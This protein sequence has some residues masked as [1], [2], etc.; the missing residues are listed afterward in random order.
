VETAGT[1][2]S[3]N[4][5][6]P[7]I[8][9]PKGGG[10]LRSIGEKFGA[11]PVT[12]TGTLSIPIATS[13]GRSGFGP[14][15]GLSYDSGAGNGPFGFGWHLSLPSITRKTDKGLPRYLD[16]E[17][18]D[19]FIFAGA[20]DLVPELDSD[21]GR[22]ADTSSAPGYTIHRY[23]PRT[24]GLFARIERWTRR[25]DGDVHWRS[26]SRDN[27]L[28]LYGEDPEAR[29]TDPADPRRIFAWL[30]CETRDSWGNAVRYTYKPEDGAGVD[31]TR[32]HERTRGGPDD[33][34]RTANRYLKRVRY[35]NRVPLLDVTGQRPIS[36]TTTQVEDAGWM[37]EVVLDYGE[38]DSD[39]PTPHDAGP[40]SWRDDPFSSYRSG[41]EV[42]TGRR[43]RRVLMFHHFPDK[44]EIGDDCLVSSTDFT[45]DQEQ[46]P[47]ETRHSVYSFLRTVTRTGYRRHG[48]GY[49]KRSLP[50][51]ELHYSQPVVQDTV[52]DLDSE[53]LE[54]LPIG[55]DGTAYRWTDLHGEGIP[56]ILTE[57][58]GAWHYKR[59]LSPA[60]EHPPELAPLELVATKPNVTLAGDTQF[61]DLAGDGQP[62]VVVLAGPVPG[63]YEHDDAGG[64][65]PF[66]PFTFPLNRDPRDPWLRFVDLDG[67]G[68]LDVLVGEDDAFTWQASRAEAGF[69][70]P[71]RVHAALDEEA[72][73]RQ[74]LSDGTQSIHLADM[75]GDGLND[76]VRIRNGEVCYW[77]NLG[78]GRF[79]AKVTMDN[80][81]WFDQPDQFDQRRIR[82]ADIDGSGTADIIY[83]ARD[84]VRLYFNQC[85]NSW[86]APQRLRVFP[87]IDDLVT[88]APTDLLGNGA[89]CLVWSSALPGDEGRQMRYVDLIG[90]Q[91]PHLLVKVVNNLG[92]ETQVEYAPSTKFYLQ[93]RR[94]GAPWITRLP[95]PVHV[96]ERVETLDRIGGNR[97]TTQ[98]AYHHGYFDGEEREFRG[99][100][101]VEQWDTERPIASAND[102]PQPAGPGQETTSRV[103]PVLT[104]TW[105]HTGI[106]RGR[107]H[108]SDFFAGLLDES[109]PGEYYREPGLTD[110]QAR[111]RLL[112]DTVL[113]S[114]LAPEEQREACRALKGTMLRQEIYGL[115]G[116]DR[117]AVPYTVS[118][119]CFTIRRV[120]PRGPNRHAVFFTH[121]SEVISLNYERDPA[122]PRMQHA[123][124]LEVDPYGN[125]LKEIGVGYG[126]R[127][128]STDPILTDADRVRQSRLLVTYTESSFTNPI[129]AADH[130][131]T[132]LPAGTRTYELAGFTPEGGAERFSLDE[133]VRDGFSSLASAV[134]IPY[135]QAADDVTRQKRLVEHIRTRYR[136]DDLTGLLPFGE[137][138]PLGLPGETYR[139]ALTPG[140]LAKV[141][142][143]QQGGQPDEALLPD[144]GPL[145]EAK[146]EDQGGYRMLDGGWWI[147]SGAVF[148]HPEADANDP[149]STATLE[150]AGARQH[151]YLPRKVT[152]P[153]GHS[154]VV[155]YDEHDLL[156][157]RTGD[158][159]GN[160]TSAANDY[161]VLRPGVITDANHNQT[162][163]AFD[164]L[165]MVVATAVMGKQ[166][167]GVGDRLEDM[168]ADPPLADVQ[169]FAADPRTRAPSLLGKATTRIV[170]DLARFQRVGQPAFA[171][172]LARETHLHE[173]G[174]DQTRIQISCTYSDGFGREIQKKVQA[175]A[176]DAPQRQTPVALPTG[177]V[178][179]GDLMRDAQGNPLSA[180]TPDRWVGSGRTVFN[181]KGKPVRQYEPFFSATH[182]YE[183]EPEMTDTGVSA[184]LFYDPIERLVAALHP[185]HTYDKTVFGPWHQT[186]WDVNDTVA[187]AGDQTGDPRTDPDIAAA[188]REYFDAQPP[189]WQTWH[190]QRIDGQLGAAERDAARQAAVHADTP[191]T[192][193]LD[194]LGRRFLTVARNRSERDGAIIE[195]QHANRVDLDLE[196][197]QRTL[198]DAKGRVVVRLDYDLLGKLLHQA[199]MEAGE[200]WILSDAS[201][202][203]IR[204][205]DGR[206][207]LRRMTYDTLRRPTGLL[208]S[209]H[210]LERLAERT[211]YGETQGDAGNHRTRV[212]QVFDGAGVATSVAYDFK[213][214]LV[215][216]RRELLA[217]VRE[218]VDW[219][220]TP[221]VEAGGFTIRTTLDALNRPSSV[222]WPDG[223]VYRPA[224]SEANLLDRVEVRLRGAAV[225]T[226]FV[227]G[228]DHDAK[229]QRTRVAFGNGT[230]TTYDYDPLTFRLV[231]LAT[232]RPATPDVT[233]SRLFRDS[234]MVQ[235]LRY[236]YDPA[237]N[238][239]RVEDAAVATVFHDG[240]QVDA[241][242]RYVYDARYRLIEARGREHIGQTSL[243]FQPP[244]GDHRDYP[245]V[246]HRHPNDL[247]ALR[248]YTERYIYDAAGNLETWRHLANGGGWTRSYEYRE[249]SLIEAGAP[250]NRLTRTTIGNGLDRVEP[251]GHDAHGN[252]V[253]M[254]HLP[255]LTW[256]F[257]DQLRQ[258]QLGGGART[259]YHYD[260]AG[261][262]LRK[263]VESPGGVRLRERIRLGGF[264]VY[265]EFGGDGAE[266]LLERESLHVLDDRQPVALV[267]TRTVADGVAVDAPASLH[268]YQLG[269]HLGS[270]SVEL[271]ADGALIS[272]EEYHPYGTTAFQ[273]GR[274]AAETSA[275]RYRYCAKERDEESGLYYHGARYSCPWLG[276]WLSPDPVGTADS[277]NL[278]EFAR[279]NP[280]NAADR[281]GLGVW[282]W[283]HENILEPTADFIDRHGIDDAVAGFGD[284]LSFGLS[285]KVRE[286][287]D[288][289]GSVDY[290]SSA[291][292]AGSWA[293]AAWGVGI[294]GASAARVIGAFGWVRG[295]GIVAGTVLGQHALTYGLD[296]VDPSGWS[297]GIVNSALLVAPML[298]GPTSAKVRLWRSPLTESEIAAAAEGGEPT[299]GPWLRNIPGRALEAERYSGQFESERFAGT[300]QQV[301]FHV[302]YNSSAPG[303]PANAPPVKTTIRF[304]DP[305]PTAKAGGTSRNTT[306]LA[307]EQAKGKRRLVVDPPAPDAGPDD[308]NPT[309]WVPK[310]SASDA[311]WAAAHIRLFPTGG[312]S[313]LP[314]GA[315]AG[316]GLNVLLGKLTRPGPGTFVDTGSGAMTT[317][318]GAAVLLPD[319]SVVP[320]PILI[321]VGTRF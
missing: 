149:A 17:E 182:L 321:G 317:I 62:D 143:R 82:L 101:M 238:Q 211:V 117:A 111:A 71:R 87:R 153:F 144:P 259:H 215:E 274:N 275:K 162:A 147:A 39:A 15:L 300:G 241:V 210:G 189:T 13:P 106:Y 57:Q 73:P 97:F 99:F 214:N 313:W 314:S 307:I 43:C 69:G 11:N 40:W 219:A 315:A 23:L 185:N 297:S 283:I 172:L 164:A 243:D 265:R 125:V 207:F 163:V 203:P 34:G 124:R 155:D 209:E 227:T 254:P 280:A 85:G 194:V 46:D 221:A 130:Y 108:V 258:V 201:G 298:R 142:R 288:V 242:S 37:F 165:G 277:I 206:G 284:T 200:R 53:S 282:D 237:G 311:D 24:E 310:R 16:A 193:H 266:V 261:Q 95:F 119:Q 217:D 79:G 255:E 276:R 72:G 232:T 197:N 184:V 80:A 78:Y 202:K 188:V 271:D 290:G 9:L 5:G 70:P 1:L 220:Q 19:V 191:T 47:A 244:A 263:V 205:W 21:R 100:G 178:R 122:D 198:T 161:R 291:Y 104:R 190:A 150:L 249:D 269:N 33:P 114:G 12:G 180:S 286:G 318:D 222:V 49:L 159:L 157:I 233:A 306:T 160:T 4:A 145:L 248:N 129:L 59:N 60:S 45:Y 272:Y 35:G 132:P 303:A 225:A 36:L 68:L 25:S 116:S 287:L 301:K 158:A 90:G 107:D 123:L 135:E 128:A 177:D 112:P 140:L 247:Q 55:V 146:G 77:P 245:M 61:L 320:E 267:E 175:K 309:R 126:R 98:Y 136:R 96:V 93:D 6:M 94:D 138:E 103:P 48:D 228:I 252:V 139:L 196:G 86:S 240:E 10:A 131:R 133:W 234:T 14:R 83:L 213:G 26:I 296:K 253:V 109:D 7:S 262:R 134:E 218:P 166:G 216:S 27:V 74:V 88:V 281:T 20:E 110:A 151:F 41:F 226:P 257:Q 42:R 30:L 52:H 294:G 285:R 171:A 179:P 199:S 204:S 251:Y 183:P 22:V 92:A 295:G 279:S 141:F 63:L 75:C 58:A 270:A 156:A 176:G 223:S 231:R 305:D 264:E 29:V 152:N 31:F 170:Y 195:E 38:H 50:A 312:L 102:G 148:L 236:T 304:H 246:G 81:P 302:D 235:D 121:V 293:G 89:A 105:F 120:Q 208:V 308:P 168:A 8:D 186:S 65:Q 230:L 167:E 51:L 212:F 229:G 256:D 278:Y 239:T 299:T 174:A 316:A 154:T 18:S 54:Q 3:G 137:L 113:P 28:T 250:S 84:G 187:A 289:D 127:T 67:D 115:D 173:P 91:K 44:P 118:E 273:A 32:A 260:S 76:L 181:N 319:E 268:R 292:G 56:G 2:G 192:V 66:R 64:W 169:A 224:Y